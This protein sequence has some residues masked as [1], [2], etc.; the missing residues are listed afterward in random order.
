MKRRLEVA[1]GL[2]HDP[3]VLFLDEPT[4]GLDPQTRNKIWEYIKNLNKEKGLS[5]ILTTHYM[6]EADKLCDRIA[7]I[8]KGKIMVLDTPENLK[9]KIGGDIISIETPNSD[10]LEAML[11]NCKWCK[12]GKKHDGYITINVEKVEKNLT[13]IISLANKNKIK[14]SSL[15]IHKPTLED[16]FL[17]FTGR[18]IREEEAKSIETMRLRSRMW[19]K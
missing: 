6:E 7:I 13:K 9:N 3:K 14:I 16:V 10:K 2:L 1:R 4:L 15:T 19:R 8:D 12:S 5:I 11:K 17:Y 18:T